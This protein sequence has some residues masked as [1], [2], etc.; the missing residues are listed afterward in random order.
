MS[1]PS[2]ELMPCWSQQEFETL[3]LGD[4]RLTQRLIEVAAELSASPQSAIHAACGDWAAA[5]AAYRLFDNEKVTAGAILSPHFQRTI[6]R[7]ESYDRVFAVQDTTYLDYTHHPSTAGLGPIGTPSQGIYGFVKHTT[8]VF[9]ESGLPLGCLSDAVWVRDTQDRHTRN[10]HVPLTEKESYKWIEA[11]NQ[12]QARTPEGV[13]VI[14]I[15]DREADI[16]EFFVQAQDT[17]FV[18]RAAQNRNVDDEAG[19]LRAL[20]QR[21]PAAGQQQV[22]IPARSSDPAREATV[23]IHFTTTTLLPPYRPP[24]FHPQKLPAIDVS[25]VWVTEV[26]PPVDAT[27]LQWLLITNVKVTDFADAIQRIR[28]YSLRWHIEVYF[29]VL[30]SGNNIEQCRLQTKDRLLRYIALKSVIAWRLYWLT[31]YK[32]HA[33]DA[34]CTCVLTDNEWKALYCVTHKKTTVPE[35]LP[36]VSQVV[37]W[38]AKLGGFLAR[39]SDPEPGVTVIWRGWQRLSD[40]ADTFALLHNDQTNDQH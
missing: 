11:F 1:T 10:T 35:K 37:I 25:V 30:K 36:T 2:D 5:K 20:V 23:S 14:S 18:I 21:Q 15:C 4:K 12:T 32:R 24:A 33:P 38:I 29:K 28:W 27:P 26:H 22:K 6:E 17:P 9:T 31:M 40:I 8:L 16:Y 7:M 19:Q 34:D 3:D 13:E 39:K